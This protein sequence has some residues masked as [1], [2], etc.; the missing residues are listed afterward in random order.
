MKN[1]KKSYAPEFATR[2]RPAVKTMNLQV[3]V[4]RAD[5][6]NAV[7]EAFVLA[8]SGGRELNLDFNLQSLAQEISRHSGI[9]AMQS[10]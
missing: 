4:T 5:L 10:V 1:T 2:N 3:A 8:K 6:K 9:G 7:R